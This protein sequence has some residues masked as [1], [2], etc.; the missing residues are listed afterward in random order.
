MPVMI[1]QILRNFSRTQWPYLVLGCLYLLKPDFHRIA[2]LETS[3]SQKMGYNSV[4]C[5][6]S[7]IYMPCINSK[8]TKMDS[9]TLNLLILTSTMQYSQEVETFLQ[10]KGGHLEA[11]HTKYGTLI[12]PETVILLSDSATCDHLPNIYYVPT[13]NIMVKQFFPMLLQEQILYLES[14]KGRMCSLGD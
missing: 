4:L 14:D 11:L 13:H 3:I 8:P 5:Q 7:C 6:P 2:T 1:F 12:C 10:K 9:L